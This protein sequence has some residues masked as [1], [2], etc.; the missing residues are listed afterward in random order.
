MTGLSSLLGGEIQCIESAHGSLMSGGSKSAHEGCALSQYSKLYVLFF[1]TDAASIAIVF[2]KRNVNDRVV[3]SP[4]SRGPPRSPIVAA[5]PLQRSPYVLR[6]HHSP[7]PCQGPIK[8]YIDS[9]KSVAQ[10]MFL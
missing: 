8:P 4:L 7:L 6:W 2:S 3:D 9:C 5:S 1:A 10:M